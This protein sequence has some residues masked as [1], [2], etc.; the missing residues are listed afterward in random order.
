M[1]LVYEPICCVYEHVPI[2]TGILKKLLASGKKEIFFMEKKDHCKQI[3][4]ELVDYELCNI[5]FRIIIT[6]ARKLTFLN[7]FFF[8]PEKHLYRI[9]T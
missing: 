2:N 7:R 4:A 8:R 3:E 5:R 9:R 6:P 1:I